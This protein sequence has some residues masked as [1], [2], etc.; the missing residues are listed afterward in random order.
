[1][2]RILVMF[3][4]AVLFSVSI[5]AKDVFK[6]YPVKSGMILY[7]INTS[8]E[9]PGLSTHTVG[10][11]RLV[12]DDWGAKE[13]KEDDATEVQRGDFNEEIHRHTMSK[14]DYGTIYTVDYDEN[15]TYQ[16]RDMDMDMAI[17][18]GTDLSNESINILKEMKAIKAGEDEVA[19]YKCDVWKAKDQS[20]CLY[21]GIPLKISVETAGFVSTRIAQV[22]TLDEDIPKEQFDLPGFAVM[23]DEG[24]TSNASSATHTADFIQA[25]KD[26]GAKFKEMK[27]DLNDSNQTFSKSEEEDIINTLGAGYLEKQKKYLPDLIVSFKDARDCLDKAEYEK[28]A[29]QCL[30]HVN[31]INEKLGDQTSNYNYK[32]WNKDKKDKI[33]KSI[34][35]EVKDLNVTIDCVNRFNLTTKV[36]ECTE[37]SLTPKE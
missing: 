11:A 13:L 4:S 16:T 8:G 2:I 28:D 5:E 15:V 1:M 21:R 35:K 36:I 19:G 14:I 18:Q 26:L 7:D 37:G 12:F 30:N 22:I 9:S 20:I 24:Y 3:V 6:R 34:D 25:S 29:S 33:I 27:I 32:D 23:L 10:V 17:E 31:K